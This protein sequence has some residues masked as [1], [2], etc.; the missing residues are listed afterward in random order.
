[1]KTLPLIW[2]N[3]WRRP[4]RDVAIVLQIAVAFLLFGTLH[5]I[6]AAL[7]IAIDEQRAD[8]LY[9]NAAVRGDLLP[10][11]YGARIADVPGVSRVNPQNFLVGRYRDG[12]RVVGVAGDPAAYFEMN[13]YLAVPQVALSRLAT[14][15]SGAIVGRALAARHGWQPGDLVT[16]RADVRRR[17]G[18]PDWPFEIV[19]IYDY[20]DEPDM[21]TL[22]IFDNE[23]LDGARADAGVAKVARFTVRVADAQAAARVIDAIDTLFVNSGHETETIAEV[24]SARSRLAALG[25]IGFVSKAISLAAL[26][27]LVLS[28]GTLAMNAVRERTAEFGLLR[29]LGFSRRRIGALIF[30]EWCVRFLIG[31]VVGL[32]LAS[33]LIP[34]A[35][36]YVGLVELPISVAIAGVVCSFLLAALCAWLPARYVMR[37]EPA[38]ALAKA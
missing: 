7:R 17:D 37:V 14:A 18:S 36:Q 1:M 21:A 5:G 13:D 9:V 2:S 6:D 25:N 23:Y 22:L 34:L 20:P 26:A 27:A 4:G 24:E 33:Q 29:A 30:V 10:A 19:G 38:S 8:F 16:L 31:A 11:S 28:V 15:R 32:A 35:R 3:V 12:E